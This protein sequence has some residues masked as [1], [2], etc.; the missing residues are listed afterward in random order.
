MVLLYTF[1]TR[2]EIPPF[3]TTPGNLSPLA[4]WDIV[5]DT[6]KNPI[7]TDDY[8]RKHAKPWMD[9]LQ[10][11]WAEAFNYYNSL[12]LHVPISTSLYG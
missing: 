12:K 9:E 5:N 1:L 3:A 7:G 6:S 2:L 4:L 8:R 11:K 10:I